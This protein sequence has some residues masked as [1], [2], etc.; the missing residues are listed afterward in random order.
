MRL[1][2]FT[3]LLVIGIL[4]LAPVNGVAS[5]YSLSKENKRINTEIDEDTYIIEDEHYGQLEIKVTKEDNIIIAEAYNGDLLVSKSILDTESGKIEEYDSN[6]KQ[7]MHDIE[8]FVTISPLTDEEDEMTTLATPGSGYTK[9]TSEY[10][11]VWKMT[12]TAYEKRTV[13]FD[14][15]YHFI[16]SKGTQITTIVSLLVQK[17][18]KVKNI[19]AALVSLGITVIS[20]AIDMYIAGRYE[21][22]IYTYDIEVYAKNRLGLKTQKQKEVYS[23]FSATGKENVQTVVTGDKRSFSD[24]IHIGIYNVYIWNS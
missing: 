7:E 9:V 8:E 22:K 2:K 24:M 3:L 1:K 15:R 6:G 17:V 18:Y 14:K 10:S 12:G 13:T 21:T 11:S 19:P 16:F 4:L 20:G 23:M 5:A